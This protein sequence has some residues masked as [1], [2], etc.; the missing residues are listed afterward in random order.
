MKFLSHF[1]LFPGYDNLKNDEDGEGLTPI[2]LSKNSGRSDVLVTKIEKGFRDYEFSID[3][4]DEF[5]AFKIKIVASGTDQA[6]Y[7]IFE[8]IRVIAIK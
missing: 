2:D 5:T 1:E 6:K 8:D 4:I 7:P 3:G